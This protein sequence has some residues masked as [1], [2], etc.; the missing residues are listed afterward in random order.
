MKK[1]NYG[2]LFHLER[3][4]GLLQQ[5]TSYYYQYGENIDTKNYSTKEKKIR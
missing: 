4:N 1:K 2:M 3:N 5:I